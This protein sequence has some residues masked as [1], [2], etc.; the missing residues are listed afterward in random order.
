MTVVM[1]PTTPWTLEGALKSPEDW[2][3]YRLAVQEL[4][5]EAQATYAAKRRLWVADPQNDLHPLPGSKADAAT[6]PV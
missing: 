3:E 5:V 1:V 4:A 2:A 6:G